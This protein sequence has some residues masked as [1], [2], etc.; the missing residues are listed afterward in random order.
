MAF[1]LNG[2]RVAKTPTLLFPPS[3]GGLT[4]GDQVLRIDSENPKIS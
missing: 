4:V 2:E 3:R 1:G